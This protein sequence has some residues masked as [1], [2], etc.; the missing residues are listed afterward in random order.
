[1]INAETTAEDASPT[2]VDEFNNCWR[3]SYSGSGLAVT[4]L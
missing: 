4:Q 3:C 1:M 2:L